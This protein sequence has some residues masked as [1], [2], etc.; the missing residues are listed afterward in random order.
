MYST[1]KL[2][3][4]KT[5]DPNNN[6]KNKDEKE[7]ENE[8]NRGLENLINYKKSRNISSRNKRMSFEAEDYDSKSP[9]ISIEPV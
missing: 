8:Q 7:F 2:K 3:K 6:Y 9:K 4:E 1:L 5:N